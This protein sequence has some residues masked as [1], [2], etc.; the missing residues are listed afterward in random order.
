MFLEIAL[1]PEFLFHGLIGECNDFFLGN[2]DLPRHAALEFLPEFLG[3]L[4]EHPAYLL[5]AID[6]IEQGPDGAVVQLRIFME[7]IPVGYRLHE[8]VL[9]M[10]NPEN[11]FIGNGQFLLVSH[12]GLQHVE[13][14]LFEA[15]YG[16]REG[17]I[18]EPPQEGCLHAQVNHRHPMVD[19][20]PVPGPADIGG[21]ENIGCRHQDQVGFIQI[22]MIHEIL[23]FICLCHTLDSLKQKHRTATMALLYHLFSSMSVRILIHYKSGTAAG[24]PGKRAPCPRHT[25]RRR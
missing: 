17:R 21:P 20:A 24:F 6:I 5:I 13:P 2:P 11:F 18:Q 22:G 16:L 15:V 12:A 4:H 10:V 19:D 23:R 1:V 14:V 3:R 8:L 9:E 25:R 7:G